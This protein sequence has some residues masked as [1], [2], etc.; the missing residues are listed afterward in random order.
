ML[1]S[2]GFSG[3]AQ[4]RLSPA[5][6]FIPSGRVIVQWSALVLITPVAVISIPSKITS[7]TL[8]DYSVMTRVCSWARTVWVTKVAVIAIIKAM[9][10][11]LVFMGLIGLLV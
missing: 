7:R 8:E 9:K 1:P 5:K 11:T 4:S 3:S 10:R 6:L 2:P